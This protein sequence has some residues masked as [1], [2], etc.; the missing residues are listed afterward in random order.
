[1]MLDIMLQVPT[2]PF[3]GASAGKG[4]TTSA[5]F[6]SGTANTAVG[7]EALKG[8]TTGIH[9]V[10]IGVSAM[11]DETTGNYNTALGNNALRENTTGGANVALGYAAGFSLNGGNYNVYH[12]KWSWDIILLEHQIIF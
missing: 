9:N 8:F 11:M 1:M 6:S 5:P 12:R 2:T 3:L 10:A 7:Y 4:G